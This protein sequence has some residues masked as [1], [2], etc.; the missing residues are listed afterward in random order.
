MRINPARTTAFSF[1]NLTNPLL[2]VSAKAKQS[3]PG[4]SRLHFEGTTIFYYTFGLK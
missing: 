2:K 3:K 4:Q 1:S